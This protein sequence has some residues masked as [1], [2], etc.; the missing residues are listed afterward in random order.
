VE[1]RLQDPGVPQWF[2]LLEPAIDYLMVRKAGSL[3][4][5]AHD[6]KGGLLRLYG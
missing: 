3:E 1:H 4:N 6:L 5:A 2:V